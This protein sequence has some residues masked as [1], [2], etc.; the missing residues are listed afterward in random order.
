M[1]NLPTIE[2]MVSFFKENLKIIVI[3]AISFLAIFALGTGYTIYTDN[4]IQNNVSET[5]EENTNMLSNI[6]ESIPLEEQLEPEEIEMIMDHLQEDGV[7]FSFYLEKNSAEPFQ[8][9]GLLKE[10]LISPSTIQEIEQKA[11]TEFEINPQLAVDVD[12]N[13]N[14]LLMTVTI[15]T[16]NAERN[17]SLANAYFDMLSNETNSF[18]DNKTVYIVNGPQEI[19]KNDVNEENNE[20]T[21]TETPVTNNFSYKRTAVFAVIIFILG[22]FAGIL[23][24]L[25]KS[26]FKNEVSG[27][28]SFAVKDEDVI[29]NL[30]TIKNQTENEKNNQLSHALL[31]PERN[32]KLILSEKKLETNFVKILKERTN[33]HL[34]KT[35]ISSNNDSPVVLLANDIVDINP[36]TFI[37]EVIFICR[38]NETTK[39]WYENQRKLLEVY[40]TVVK[41]ILI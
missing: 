36:N 38:K 15:G 3:T 41:V 16:R 23:I 33:V 26:L 5:V 34:G 11:E 37:D 13:S 2:E 4:K 35:Y 21:E 8:A 18:F 19:Y 40:K 1:K 30:S 6:D 9:T 10:L 12:F 22:V 25:L 17:Q 20:N 7:A 39:E 29:L 27:I 24:A 28:Y 14:N 31:H 32:T